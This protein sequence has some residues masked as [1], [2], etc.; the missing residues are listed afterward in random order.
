M[1]PDNANPAASNPKMTL[2]EDMGTL[3]IESP[4]FAATLLRQ[5]RDDSIKP[6]IRKNRRSCQHLRAPSALRKRG[7]GFY[8]ASFASSA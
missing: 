5:K 2:S 6:I 8:A 4:A 3:P 7:C 1:Q